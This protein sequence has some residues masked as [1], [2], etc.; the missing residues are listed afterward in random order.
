MMT[1]N[2][3]CGSELVLT[4]R[5]IRG[6]EAAEIGLVNRAVR[7]GEVLSTARAIAGEM[8]ACD[9]D[10][11]ALAKQTLTRGPEGTIRD[12]LGT[13]KRASDEL[14]ARRA[15]RRLAG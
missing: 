3:A 11:L 14:A 1:L 10:A 7:G 13:E 4:A 6:R 15:A 5:L 8:A 9:P 2:A 12:A